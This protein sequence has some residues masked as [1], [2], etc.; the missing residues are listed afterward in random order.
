MSVWFVVTLGVRSGTKNAL[1]R[2]AAHEA[3]KKPK[4]FWLGV[5]EANSTQ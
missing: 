2:E 5:C 3:A 4:A 1:I